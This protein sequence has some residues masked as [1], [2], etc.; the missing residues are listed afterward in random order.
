M[1]ILVSKGRFS[2]KNL[3]SLAIAMDVEGHWI[4]E[5]FENFIHQSFRVTK[6]TDGLQPFCRLFMVKGN[7]VDTINLKVMQ[8]R[9]AIHDHPAVSLIGN[10]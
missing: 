5:I 4:S 6:K 7:K 2:E 10:V 8:D 3:L 9:S 1:E